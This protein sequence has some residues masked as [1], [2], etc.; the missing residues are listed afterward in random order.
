MANSDEVT[1][2]PVRWGFVGTGSIANWMASV[3]QSL[4]TAELAAVA[5]RRIE[6]A[7]AFAGTHGARLPFASWEAMLGCD[8]VDAV[9]VATPT[10]LRE[11]I[12]VAAAAAGKHVLGEKPFASHDS[13]RR[14]TAACREHGVAFM[15]ATHFVHHQ[16]TASI[17]AACADR[18]GRAWSL[19]SAFLVSLL[20]RDDI[21]FDPTLEPMG[22][23]GDLG[24]Y[25]M[26]AAVEYLAPDQALRSV[27]ARLRRDAETGVT[28]AAS[29][30]IEF[31]DDATSTF[32][33]AFD[34]GA[35]IIEMRI[36]GTAGAIRTR[37]FIGQDEDGSASYVC[38]R[39]AGANVTE[40]V[41]RVPS[42]WSGPAL[43][44]LDFAAAVQ[45]ATLRERWMHS[46]ERTQELLDAA[47]AAGAE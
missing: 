21:R 36:A 20:N 6:T 47:W 17:R 32:N 44:F 22:A 3:V 13:I 38:R 8:E 33:C 46:S 5:S 42:E 12:S 9:Y 28:I 35:D 1:R 26:R 11:E 14:I 19:D 40:E 31:S 27:S 10:S 41:V 43:M 39:G 45:D 25:N 23:L 16:R 18:V 24:W 30:V 15:D 34:S 2:R 29:G 4:P 7:T 37:N